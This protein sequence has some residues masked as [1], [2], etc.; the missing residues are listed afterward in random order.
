M[1]GLWSAHRGRIKLDE[2]ENKVNIMELATCKICLEDSAAQ[3]MVEDIEGAKYCYACADICFNCG[4]YGHHCEII[5]GNGELVTLGDDERY[6]DTLGNYGYRTWLS[7][8]WVCY[9]DGVYCDCE[10]AE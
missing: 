1:R 10:S 6:T 4:I 5:A 3:D 8:S 7:G 9:T 2:G